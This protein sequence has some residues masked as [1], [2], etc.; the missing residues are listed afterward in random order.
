MA[1]TPKGPLA[2]ANNLTGV[3]QVAITSVASTAQVWTHNFGAKP[4]F[5]MA[6]SGAVQVNSNGIASAAGQV[7]LTYSTS[8]VTFTPNT[9]TATVDLLLCW[10]LPTPFV[11]GIQSTN[12]V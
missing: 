3:T 11:N 8:A 6:F 5:G 4:L 9:L 10:A 2:S 1:T 12:F 7:A